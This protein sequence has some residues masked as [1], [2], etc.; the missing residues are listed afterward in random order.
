[1]RCFLVRLMKPL[2]CE[3]KIT[4]LSLSVPWGSLI[5]TSG[6]DT[7]LSIQISEI[8]PG[9]LPRRGEALIG[10]CITSRKGSPSIVG[11]YPKFPVCI[12]NGTILTPR[13]S[14]TLS[15]CLLWLL[16]PRD[17]FQSEFVYHWQVL[18]IISWQHLT[19]WAYFNWTSQCL[20][21]DCLVFVGCASWCS[22]FP[23]FVLTFFINY[24]SGMWSLT[25]VGWKTFLLWYFTGSVLE[26]IVEESPR[27]LFW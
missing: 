1:M 12:R 21:D 7:P 14:E 3:V 16:L 26:L 17:Q 2:F 20:V 18:S 6:R 5:P 22:G 9:L 19:F 11:R 15:L 4:S 27:K 23:F 24:L 8:S 10:W 13:K 25:V